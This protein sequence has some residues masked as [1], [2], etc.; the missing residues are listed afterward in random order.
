MLF[1]KKKRSSGR[2]FFSTDCTLVLKISTTCCP[3]LCVTQL[4]TQR[5]IQAQKTWQGNL[6][7]VTQLITQLN[8]L[9]FGVLLWSYIYPVNKE[10]QHNNL[11]LV[12]QLRKHSTAMVSSK[13]V[14]MFNGLLKTDCN[15]MVSSKPLK[16]PIVSFKIIENSKFPFNRSQ[17]PILIF[18]MH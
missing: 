8:Y 14:A 9:I 16:L 2:D 10:L 4:I 7:L 17:S 12:T 18:S 1:K 5:N 15:S 6:L 3:T 13:T 11:L